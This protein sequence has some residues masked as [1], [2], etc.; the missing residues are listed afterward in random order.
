M[1]YVRGT[2]RSAYCAQPSAAVYSAPTPNSRFRLTPMAAAIG[3]LTLPIA[4]V[5]V[6]AETADNSVIEELVVTA[7]RRTTSVQD[8]PINI[9]ALGGAQIE[10]QGITDLSEIAAWVPGLHIVDQ[11]ARAADRIVVRGLNADP[12][13]SSE[14]LNNGGGG[15]VATYL[16]EIP[17]YVDLKLN[18][19]ER[20]EV[21]L[22]PQG[23]LYGA[24]TMGGAIRYI[25]TKP[26]LEERSVS[27]RGDLF[28]YSESEDPGTDI[29]GTLNIPIGSKAAIRANIDYLDDPGFIDYDFL[30]REIG[31]S[32]PDPDFSDPTAVA[33]NLRSR[34]DANTEETVSG[35]IALRVMPTDRIDAT[36][37]YYYQNGDSGG[38]TIN[39]RQA[40]GTGRYSSA[41]RVLEPSERENQLTS[42]EVIAD[43][44]FAEL[45]SATGYSQYDEVGNRDQTDL[46]ITLEYSYEAFPSF[47]S[48][49][50]E[51]VEEKTFT[52]ELRLVSTSDGPLNW[53]V[54]G[55]YNDLEADASSRE[56]TPGYDE[57]AVNNFG[58]LGLRP[59]SLEYFSVDR[60]ELTELAVYGELQYQITDDWQVTVGARWYDYELETQSAVDFPLLNTV[61][62]GDAPDAINLDFNPGGQEDDGVLFKFNTSYHLN[63]DVMAYLTVSE[64]YR[65]G[66]SNG[67]ALCPDPLPVNQI[68][69]ALPNEFEFFPDETLNYEVGIRSTLLDGRLTLNGAAYFIDWKDPQVASA[70]EN[71]LISI[72]VNGAGAETRGFEFSW[73]WLF[74]DNW[75]LRGNFAFTQAELNATTERLV[76]G[77]NPPGFQGTIT[78]EDGVSGDRLPGS[79]ERQGALFLSNSRQV[80]N[81]YDLDLTYGLWA[82]GDVITR[83]GGK[84]GGETL[85]GYAIH[86]FSASLGRDNWQATLYADNLLD[87]YAETAARNT[88]RFNQTVADINGDP[89]V[90]R[91]YFHNVLPPRSIGVRVRWDFN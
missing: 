77:I 38:R 1:S 21:L 88:S 53:I 51:E 41:L 17:V 78:Y 87:K 43:L 6:F 68:A 57:F 33:A 18:D 5:A 13:A 46:L 76:P 71:A 49:T 20:V 55:F 84:G 72:T 9:S 15:T 66:N 64:G 25:P 16:G 59:D 28:T 48:R 60:R 24:G 79:P 3:A 89:V 47:T 80:G 82:V 42:L 35:R 61:F 32:N 40:F 73:N 75:S 52:Q 37:T 31:V 45:T 58:G 26:Q 4:P 69:C 23:T 56:F 90:G 39:S 62:F 2:C 65:I 12:L 50:L 83:A 85:S 7:T 8:V 81:G 54:G 70:T 44:G 11:G 63:D 74:A 10:E 19:M 67:V 27:V 22:G 29:G 30:V 34:E 91:S 14:G 36:L 86:N